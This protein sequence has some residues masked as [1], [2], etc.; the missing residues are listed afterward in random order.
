MPIYEGFKK[1]AATK[2]APLW[3]Q[4]VVIGLAVAVA[5]FILLAFR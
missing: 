5:D 4:L 1:R 2:E 3:L